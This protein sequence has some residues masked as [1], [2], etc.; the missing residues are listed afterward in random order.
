MIFPWQHLGMA[1]QHLGTNIQIITN[2][3]KVHLQKIKYGKRT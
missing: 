1:W 3:N 2:E